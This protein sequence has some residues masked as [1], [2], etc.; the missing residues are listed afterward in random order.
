V[1]AVSAAHPPQVDAAA[2]QAQLDEVLWYHTIAVVPGALTRGW[3]DLRHALPLLPFPEI[4]GRRCLDVGTWDGFYAYELEARGAAEVVAVDLPDLREIDW[5]PEVRAHPEANPTLFET[6][7]PRPAGFELVKAIRG[8]GVEWRGCNIYD[9]H[10]DVVGTFDLVVVGSLLVHL[11]DPVRA[12]DA[13]RSVV[14]PGGHLLLADYIHPPVNVLGR[15]RP[16]FELRGEGNDFQWWLASDRGLQQLLHVAGFTVDRASKHF[17]LRPGT[18]YP[19]RSL[20]PVTKRDRVNQVL[21]WRWA[22]D[23]TLGGHLHR[24]YLCHPRF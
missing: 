2:V 19:V 20:R 23:A 22:R 15:G 12:L 4:V 5:P 13:V 17:L 8:S 24:A 18:H 11:R 16:L 14:R 7:Q 21:N 10:P 9:L 3:W 6:T 1:A